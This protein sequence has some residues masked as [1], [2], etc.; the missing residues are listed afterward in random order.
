MERYQIEIEIQFVKLAGIIAD[1][2]SMLQ[3]LLLI[4]YF[5]TKVNNTMLLSRI[6]EALI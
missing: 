5:L 3:T 6:K 2:S 1:I 4:G